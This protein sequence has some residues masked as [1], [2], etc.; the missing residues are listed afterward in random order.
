MMNVTRSLDQLWTSAEHLLEEGS[1]LELGVTM[2]PT[3]MYRARAYTPDDHKLAL[4]H[5]ATPNEA[6][7]KLIAQLQ[8][9]R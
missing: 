2:A 6:M 9:R 8:E 5:G 3:L 4:A 1:S 7:V